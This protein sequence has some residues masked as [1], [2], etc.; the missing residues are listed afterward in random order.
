[1]MKRKIWRIAYRAAHVI[2]LAILLFPGSSAAL[3]G[4]SVIA[5]E[6]IMA[7]DAVEMFLIYRQKK[8]KVYLLCSAIF[9]ITLLSIFGGYFWRIFL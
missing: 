9:L 8:Q 7:I 3:G 2:L 4:W 1:M 6:V 5:F